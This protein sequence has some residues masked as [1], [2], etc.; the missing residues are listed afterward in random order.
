[1]TTYISSLTLPAFVFEQPAVSVLLPVVAGAAIGAF[2]RP[3]RTKK[4]YVALK[5]PPLHPPPQVFGP[6]WTLL[7]ATMGYAAYRAWNAGT[8]SLSLDKLHLSREGATL[9]TIQL[10]LNLIWMPLF[11]GFGRPIEATADIAALLGV[12]GYLAYV[13]GQV[14]SVSG[15]LLTP[16]LAW[17]GFAGYLSAGCG[18]LNNWDFK[19]IEKR[20][21]DA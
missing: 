12:N 3:D 1:M 20:A 17:L 21:K 2:T 6:V 16:Y 15:W 18:Y 13:W 10:A 4:T 7:Y 19:G 8:T 11:F 14:D 5:Q 9:Y